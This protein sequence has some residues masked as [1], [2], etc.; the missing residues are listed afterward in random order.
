M[1]EKNQIKIFQAK[2]NQ[3]EVSVQLD[4][5]TVWL[6]RNQLAT[7]FDR[8]IKTIGKHIT[9]VFKE[10]ELSKVATVAKYATVQKEGDREVTR[11]VEHYNLDVIISLGYRVKSQRGTQFRIWAISILKEHLVKGYTINEKRLAQKEQEVKDGINFLS[12]A[13]ECYG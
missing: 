1:Q 8:D 10:G 13:F 12:K 9:N 3:V 11:N 6:N 2:D 5:E 4:N 7:L